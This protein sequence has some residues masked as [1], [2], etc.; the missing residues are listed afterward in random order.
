MKYISIVEQIADHEGF[1][2]KPYRCTAGKLTIG[3][4]RNIE[5]VGISKA[6]A[7]ILLSND[8]FKAQRDCERIFPLWNY[9]PDSKRWAL[10]D[11]RF[12]LGPGRFRG[13]R[14]MIAAVKNED[15]KLAAKEA[16]D[17]RWYGQ[18]GRRSKYIVELLGDGEV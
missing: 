15:W 5:D 3:Y 7:R 9:Y 2:S 17:S 18:V 11:M 16:K 13:F 8:I 12:N 10:V 4:G 1:R 6:E 14:R